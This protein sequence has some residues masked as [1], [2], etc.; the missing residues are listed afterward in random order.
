MSETSRSNENI[1]IDDMDDAECAAMIV[2][3]GLNMLG[4]KTGDIP[5]EEFRELGQRIICNLGLLVGTPE[6]LKRRMSDI[7]ELDHVS[8][9]FIQRL[10]G[11]MRE[12]NGLSEVNDLPF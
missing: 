10:R 4:L 9:E 7:E 5:L 2:V 8:N 11:A 6:K 1:S 12:L 3:E